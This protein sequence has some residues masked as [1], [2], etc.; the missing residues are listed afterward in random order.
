MSFDHHIKNHL[1]TSRDLSEARPHE[2]KAFNDISSYIPDDSNIIERRIGSFWLT[3]DDGEGERICVIV[4][5]E[6]NAGTSNFIAMP[7]VLFGSGKGDYVFAGQFQSG[8]GKDS[9]STYGGN[10]TIDHSGQSIS[11]II[12]LNRGLVYDVLVFDGKTSRYVS[13]FSL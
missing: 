5:V 2:N 9:F 13:R 4:S 8:S 7:D 3:D 6:V 10:G 12:T 1:A 11:D